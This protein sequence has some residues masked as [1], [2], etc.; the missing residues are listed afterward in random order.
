MTVPSPDISSTE[1][2]SAGATDFD[3]DFSADA[4]AEI[5]ALNESGPETPSTTEEAPKDNPAWTEYLNGIPEAYRP[6]VREAFSRWDQGVNA[7]FQERAQEIQQLQERFKPF[8]P[9]VEKGITPEKLSAAEYLLEAISTDPKSF[10]QQLGEHLGITAEQAQEAVEGQESE[11]YDGDTGN[12]SD[13]RVAELARQQ[14]ALIQQQEQLQAYIA[15]QQ[16]A[17]E[18]ARLDAEVANEISTFQE[19]YNIPDPVM[20]EIIREA[21]LIGQQNPNVTIME[22]AR[23]WNN[24]Q[25]ALYTNR[26]TNNAPGVVPANG[27]DPLTPRKSYG[28]LSDEEFRADTL[29]ALKG[30][31]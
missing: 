9:L 2:E 16:A 24:R 5:S 27:S 22:A 15:E 26:P 23:S 10:Y 17:Q 1:V 13:P 31:T 21:V 30:I 4:A 25:K 12:L 6:K 19:Q 20:N 8:E 11:E 7:K 18:E 28:E 29:E 14:Q 3:F